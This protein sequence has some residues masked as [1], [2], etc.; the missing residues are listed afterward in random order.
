[1]PRR[2]IL[3]EEGHYYHIYN[4]GNNRGAIFFRP[5]NY[6]FFLR[7][8]KKY[9]TPYL[10]TIAYALMPTHYHFLARVK[11][12][13]FFKNSGFSEPT[14]VISNAMQRFGLSYTRAINKRFDRVG[15]LFQGVYQAKLIQTE[16][17]LLHLCRYI[18]GNPVK[19]GLVADSADW[20]Y[21]NYLEW[22]GE[23]DGTLFDPE[24]VHAYFASPE[25]YRQFILDDLLGRDLP[26]DIQLYLES[27]NK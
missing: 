19:D 24:F 9:L 23:R 17:H 11:N 1:M 22:I 10:D 2:K 3:F 27:L 20:E 8:W 12:P 26:D 5:E 13:E 7:R 14:P 16:S 15:S 4:R 25:D 6:S 18:H 21:S